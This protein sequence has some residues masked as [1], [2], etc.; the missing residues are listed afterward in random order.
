V[1]VEVYET[2]NTAL[3]AAPPRSELYCLNPV[4]A[5]STQVEGLAGYLTRLAEA[6]HVEM[7]VLL[8]LVGAYLPTPCQHRVSALR[9]ERLCERWRDSQNRSEPVDNVRVGGVD[10]LAQCLPVSTSLVFIL[11]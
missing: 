1:Q 2:W 7:G 10:R 6:H 9:V 8:E 3:P 5:G 4:G 11:L